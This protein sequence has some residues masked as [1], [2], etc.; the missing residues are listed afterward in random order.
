MRKFNSAKTV[1]DDAETRF[2][3]LPKKLNGKT[4]TNCTK[5]YCFTE[6]QEYFDAGKKRI[7]CFKKCYVKFM[8]NLDCIA[9]PTNS[10]A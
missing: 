6:S 5:R 8:L 4:T 10:N 3:I 1:F 7:E 2:K 9:S